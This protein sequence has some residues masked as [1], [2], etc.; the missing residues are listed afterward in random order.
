MVV[1]VCEPGIQ[2]K[3]VTGALAVKAQVLPEQTKVLFTEVLTCKGATVIV[4]TELLVP[5]PLLACKVYAVVVVGVNGCPLVMPPLQVK[6][7]AP[8]AVKLVLMPGQIV[9]CATAT[10]GFGTVEFTVIAMVET[11]TQFKEL[12]AVNE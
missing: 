10:L 12:V 9:L 4:Y 5:Q 6:L 2:V 3:P 7:G 1:P 8:L 11:D